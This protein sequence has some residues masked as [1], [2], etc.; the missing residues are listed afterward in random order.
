MVSKL[1]PYSLGITH[2]PCCAAE[3]DSAFWSGVMEF[4]R[5]LIW[6]VVRYEFILRDRRLSGN[7][8]KCVILYCRLF[9]AGPHFA[10]HN[11]RVRRLILCKKNALRSANLDERFGMNCERLYQGHFVPSGKTTWTSGALLAGLQ[12]GSLLGTP[13]FFFRVSVKI[14]RGRFWSCSCTAPVWRLFQGYSGLWRPI[15]ERFTQ[16]ELGSAERH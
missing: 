9:S 1:V 6:K 7:L 4:S 16:L 14:I 10:A 15:H 3:R 5:F 13:W 8:C 11:L 2:R 12:S